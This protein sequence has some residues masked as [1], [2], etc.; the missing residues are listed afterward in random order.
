MIEEITWGK[1]HV[2]YKPKFKE[3]GFD[4]KVE[5]ERK[6]YRNCDKGRTLDDFNDFTIY[7]NGEY[8]MRYHGISFDLLDCIL[9]GYVNA[10]E[11]MEKRD[12]TWI[13]VKWN[14]NRNKNRG[15]K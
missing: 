3:Y 9:F 8:N 7:I 6:G 12:K 10:F 11:L 14:S 2:H 1:T 13:R 4:L 5:L 15:V